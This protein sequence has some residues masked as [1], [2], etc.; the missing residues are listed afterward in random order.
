MFGVEFVAINI[1]VDTLR[2]ISY[3]LRMKG[4]P[5]SVSSYIYGDH[6]LVIHNT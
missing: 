4:V 5:I 3:K 1:V 2:G 6:M